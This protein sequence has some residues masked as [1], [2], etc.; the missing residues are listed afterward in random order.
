[1]CMRLHITLDE[2]LVKEIDEVAGKRGRSAFIRD[3]VAQEVDR[4]R[5]SAALDR[6]FGSIPDFGSH[7]GPDW[8]G[9]ERREATEASDRRVDEALARH[10]DPR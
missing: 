8:I 3:S 4:R 1:M 2:D 5:R 9:R 6:A 7:L 10:D